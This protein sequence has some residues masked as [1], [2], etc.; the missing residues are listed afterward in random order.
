[1]GQ[2]LGILLHEFLTQK[3]YFIKTWLILLIYVLIYYY[4]Q[5]TVHQLIEEVKH[6]LQFTV[7][8]CHARH[9]TDL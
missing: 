1:M 6:I 2:A 5:T 3:C 9:F 4:T 8:C 7:N